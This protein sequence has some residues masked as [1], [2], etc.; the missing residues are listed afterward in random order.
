MPDASWASKIN[1]SPKI[2]LSGY[3]STERKN[4]AAMVKDWIITIIRFFTS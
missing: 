3:L 1:L 4:V 2:I